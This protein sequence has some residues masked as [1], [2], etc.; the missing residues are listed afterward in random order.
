VTQ[1]HVE[2]E[3]VGYQGHAITLQNLS[4][5]RAIDNTRHMVLSYHGVPFPATW[6]K[7]SAGKTADFSAVFR[8]SASCPPGVDAPF[9]AHERISHAWNFSIPKQALAQAIGAS[10]IKGIDLYQDPSSHKVYA[11]RIHDEKGTQQIDFLKLQQTLS[12][13][14]LKSNDFTVQIKGQEVLFQGFGEGV[15]TGL[16]LLSASAMADK[17]EK[18]PKILEAFFPETQLDRKR[19]LQ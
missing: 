14:K 7:D 18:A 19:C 10:Q 6:T 9:A 17:G 1:W 3:E 8:K 16:C 15:G 5:D 12:A 11:V 13:T 4:A 2:A